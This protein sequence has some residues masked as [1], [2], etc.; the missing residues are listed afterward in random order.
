MMMSVQNII[1]S[2]DIGCGENKQPGFL[3]LDFR[4]SASVD[5]VADAS[6]LPFRDESFEHVFSSHTLE[7][8]SHNEVNR[9]VAEWV[10]ILKKGGVIEIRCPDLRARALLFFLN[11]TWYNVINIYGEQN[12]DGNYHKCGFSYGIL[13]K[14]LKNNGIINIKRIISG[15]RRIRILP[16][17]LH[18]K[19]IKK[20]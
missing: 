16:N 17:S 3:G 4:M 2:I 13:K 10:R 8:F 6:M 18:L 15:Y 19:G 12:H 9:V 1:T 14:I 7:H 5:I 11:P 20:R